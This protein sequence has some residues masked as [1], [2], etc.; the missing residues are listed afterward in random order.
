[1][2][3]NREMLEAEFKRQLDFANFIGTNQTA[4]FRKEFL[5]YALTLIKAQPTAD[6]VEVVRCKDCKHCADEFWCGYHSS[7]CTPADFC[8]YGER[9]EQFEKD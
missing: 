8:S 4:P 9:K 7:V 5:E 1:M 6:V 2:N 3:V